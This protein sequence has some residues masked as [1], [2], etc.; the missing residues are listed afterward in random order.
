M[1]VE[2]TNKWIR[3]QYGGKEGIRQI[4]KRIVEV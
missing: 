4:Y 1:M 2:W 3:K